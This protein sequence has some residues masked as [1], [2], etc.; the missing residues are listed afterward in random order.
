MTGSW[1]ILLGSWKVLEF[2]LAKTVGSLE[3]MYN[4]LSGTLN[5]TMT[6]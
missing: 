1:K 3:I 2:I 4:V 6:N 5:R